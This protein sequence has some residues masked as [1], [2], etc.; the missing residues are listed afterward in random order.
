MMVDKLYFWGNI[1]LLVLGV[2]S[3]TTVVITGNIKE[4][5]L[6]ELL[7]QNSLELEQA[8]LETAKN[9]KIAKTAQLPLYFLQIFSLNVLFMYPL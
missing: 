8:K 6:K 5:R 2:A 3:T 7:S 4:R 1:S 9:N